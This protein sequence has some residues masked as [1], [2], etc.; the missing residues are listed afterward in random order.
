MG[1]T[2]NE[3]P[4]AASMIGANA[5]D[6][7]TSIWALCASRSVEE[8]RGGRNDAWSISGNVSGIAIKASSPARSVNAPGGASFSTSPI[9]V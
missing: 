2:A 7:V 9:G 4:S 8:A 5:S 3:A 1:A 6:M